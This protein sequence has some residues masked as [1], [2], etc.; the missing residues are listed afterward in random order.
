MF[1]LVVCKNQVYLRVGLS[2]KQGI[3]LNRPYDDGWMSFVFFVGKTGLVI[4]LKSWWT[5]DVDGL[6][7]RFLKHSGAA[8]LVQ[9]RFIACFWRVVSACHWRLWIMKN[10]NKRYLISVRVGSIFMESG[11]KT[12]IQKGSPNQIAWL[13]CTFIWLLSECAQPFIWS[14]SLRFL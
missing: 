11:D 8:N 5:R 3:E 1:E 7:W 6:W 14:F 10:K 9:E 12:S 2:L 4:A 13:R